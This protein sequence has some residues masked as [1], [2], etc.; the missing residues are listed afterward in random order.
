MCPGEG[1][2]LTITGPFFSDRSIAVAKRTIKC[3]E[4]LNNCYISGRNE[5]LKL[6]TLFVEA[7]K[8]KVTGGVVGT[9]SWFC[10]M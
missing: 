7:A 2:I 6:F 4:S 10:K 3:V 9:A 8:G 5:K 1:V